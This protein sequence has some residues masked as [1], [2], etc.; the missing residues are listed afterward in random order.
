MMCS[1]MNCGSS[2]IREGT[3]YYYQSS[4]SMMK[5]VQQSLEHGDL[6]NKHIKEKSF[7]IRATVK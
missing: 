2:E 5:I 7:K 1:D 3:V 4:M 6:L